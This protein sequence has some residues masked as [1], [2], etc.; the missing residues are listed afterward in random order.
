MEWPWQIEARNNKLELQAQNNASLVEEL[1][2]LLEKLSI[3][4]EV[5]DLIC[6]V[7]VSLIENVYIVVVH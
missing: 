3:P 6:L 7:I 5:R 2:T 4:P 1:N